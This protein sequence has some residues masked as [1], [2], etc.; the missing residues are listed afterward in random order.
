MPEQPDETVAEHVHR[1]LVAGV[2]QEYDGSHQ[3]VV[4][5]SGRQQVGRQVVGRLGPSPVE[6][7]AHVIGEL[8]RCSDGRI[9]HLRGRRWFVHPH[10]RLRPAPQHRDVGPG[11]ADQLGD[12]QDGQRLGV[13]P[14]DVEAGRVHLVEELGRQ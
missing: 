9:D 8:A 3:L 11:E 10:D 13:L 4:I 12:D 1:R 7:L 5:Q 6:V 2:E 14:D